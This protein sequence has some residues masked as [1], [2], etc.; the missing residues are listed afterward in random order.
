[1]SEKLHL[2][3]IRVGKN[4]IAVPAE[5]LQEVLT[6]NFARHA[7]PDAAPFI[8]GLINVRGN[9]LPLLDLDL[10]LHP[11]QTSHTEHSYVAILR[12]ER[13]QWAMLADQALKVS[14]VEESSFMPLSDTTDQK[15]LLFRKTFIDG[16]DITPVLDVEALQNQPGMRLR[17]GITEVKSSHSNTN[18]V[19]RTVFRI[20]PLKLAIDLMATYSAMMIHVVE[21]GGLQSRFLRG[22][23]PVNGK[24]TALIDLLT[25]LGLPQAEDMIFPDRMLVIEHAGRQLAFGISEILTIENQPAEQLLSLHASG[26]PTEDL[27][28][29]SYHSPEYGEI[30]VLNHVGILGRKDIVRLTEIHKIGQPQEGKQAQE[31][32]ESYMVYQAARST[33]ATPAAA[34]HGILAYP[35]DLTWLRKG[36][37]AFLGLFTWQGR[38]IPLI[39]L[40]TL[41]GKPTGKIDVKNA[42]ILLVLAEN[43][44]RGYL[45]EQLISLQ[46]TS[47]QPYPWSNAVRVKADADVSGVPKPSQIIHLANEQLRS[48]ATVLDLAK[49]KVFTVDSA[50]MMGGN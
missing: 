48:N 32:S 6:G 20:G 11:Q 50:A 24:Q 15:P 10:L 16:N 26:I 23:C 25:L 43:N 31:Q 4:Q 8:S 13:G 46:F 27:Y 9:P 12:T 37:S 18:D 36:D 17:S 47:P 3:I 39:D 21:D 42:R 34:L 19:R 45:V 14:Q 29:G 30:L 1:M 49:I 35:A 7:L 28:L 38:S 22:F 40:S 44:L 41:L 33:L 2:G 5:N